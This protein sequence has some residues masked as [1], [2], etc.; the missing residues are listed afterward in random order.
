MKF[1]RLIAGG[2]L[3]I[4]DKGLLKADI[5]IR[6]GKIQA[7]LWPGFNAD[8]G[9]IVNAE[10]LYVFPG[11]IEPHAHLGLGYG[12]DD[13]QTETQSAAL[14]GVTTILSFLRQPEDYLDVFH[15]LKAEAEKR[16]VFDFGFHAVIMSEQHLASTGRYYHELGISSFKFY[17]TYRGA[18][19]QAMGVRGIDDGFMFDCFQTVAGLPYGRVIV[20]AENVEVVNRFK[21]RLQGQGRNDLAAWAESRPDFAEAEAARRAMYFAELTGCPLHFLHLTSRRALTEISDFKSRYAGI[22]VEVCHP[23][24]FFTTDDMKTPE[25]KVKP[26]FR[27]RGDIDALWD[28]IASGRVD[29]IGSDHVPRPGKTKLDGTWSPVTGVPGS[30]LL[31]PVM[32][33]EGYHKRKIPLA[34]IAAVTSTQTARLYNLYPRKGSLAI[35]SDADMVLVDLDREKTVRASELGSCAG[36]SPYEG[37]ILKGWPVMVFAGGELIAEN[38]NIM[39]DKGRGRYLA[40]SYKGDADGNK[41][42]YQKQAR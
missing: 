11:V 17:M 32:L 28:G 41:D 9:Q 13:F 14:G 24:L 4:P 6:M 42:P 18:D 21:Q 29:S 27:S 5:G 19:A 3:V 20:H 34:R 10:G 39:A 33:S 8:A 35:G 15:E 22:S 2:T 30:G 40:R 16:A 31:F 38:G 7:I 37:K 12:V 23:Y 1:D 36:Y 26:P 25:M